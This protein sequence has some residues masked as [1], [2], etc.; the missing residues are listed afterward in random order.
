MYGGI[1]AFAESIFGGPFGFYNDSGNALFA[2]GGTA[3][4]PF[5]VIFELPKPVMLQSIRLELSQD[6]SLSRRGTAGYTLEGLSSPTSQ[7]KILSKVSLAS[8]YQDAYGDNNITVSDT[9]T[10]PFVGRFFRL[11]VLQQDDYFAPRVKELDG[12]GLSDP[13]ITIQ[14]AS[15]TQSQ[16]VA[17]TPSLSSSVGLLK[18]GHGTLLLDSPNDF[19]G[20]TT[21]SEGGLVLAHRSAMPNSSVTVADGAILQVERNVAATVAGLSV[22]TG[23]LVDITE[24]SLRVT[25]GLTN[26]VL[27]DQLR[28][29]RGDGTW[30]GADGILSTAV[31]TDIAASIPRTIGWMENGDGS[32]TVAYSAPGD[33]TLDGQVDI[34][35]AA[36]FLV[37]RKFETGQAASWRDGDYNYDGNVDALD[38]ADFVS[39]GLYDSGPYIPASFNAEA[40]AVVPEPSAWTAGLA[41]LT[42][43]TLG[44]RRRH[45]RT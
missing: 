16:S 35:D 13:R 6:G 3:G 26:E 45:L 5:F 22:S 19:S 4:T 12:F 40:L 38:A 32:V 44:F 24:G 21:I 17:G 33:A 31:A 39:T 10:D 15:G 28:K 11:T 23:G 18:T 30:R 7:S 8:N 41:A 29:G 2:D 34:L 20:G 37:S 1:S 43:G 42:L 14:I 25:R 27:I 9:L 36:Y